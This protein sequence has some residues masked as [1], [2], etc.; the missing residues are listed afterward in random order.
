MIHTKN[1]RVNQIDSRGFRVDIHQKIQ[2][3][4]YVCQ[5][6]P[7]NKLEKNS[8][9]FL[10]E[11]QGKVGLKEKKSKIDIFKLPGS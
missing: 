6:S 1:P 10:L 9:F 4:C 7:K 3:F 11:L 2:N 5:V 8:F